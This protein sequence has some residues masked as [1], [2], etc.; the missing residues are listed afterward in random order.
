MCVSAYMRV[1][2]CVYVFRLCIC[3]YELAHYTPLIL[4]LN[5]FFTVLFISFGV[6]GGGFNLFFAYDNLEI[7]DSNH[8]PVLKSRV[9]QIPGNITFKSSQKC[10][11]YSISDEFLYLMFRKFSGRIWNVEFISQPYQRSVG[12]EHCLYPSLTLKII[13][14]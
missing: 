2:T 13:C 11:L 6:W 7:N 3:E 9:C 4:N 12:T 5:I 8:C 1:R 14:I 10:S